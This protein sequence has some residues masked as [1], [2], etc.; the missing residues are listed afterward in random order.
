MITLEILITAYSSLGSPDRPSSGE[1][2]PIL[3]DE[4]LLKEIAAKRNCT[5]AQVCTFQGVNFLNC[6]KQQFFS[7]MYILK[8]SFIKKLTFRTT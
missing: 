7:Q 2:D 3:M 6:L 1:A 4:P 5:P 8:V